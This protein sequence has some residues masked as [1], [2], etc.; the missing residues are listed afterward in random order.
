[1]R[2]HQALLSIIFGI[3]LVLVSAQR[4]RADF[5]GGDAFKEQATSS[6]VTCHSDVDCRAQGLQLVLLF[7]NGTGDGPNGQVPT[8]PEVLRELPRLTL[9]AQ[10][11]ATIWGDTILEGSYEAAGATTLDRVEGILQNGRLVSYRIT[12]SAKAWRL[13]DDG[14]KC[15]EGRIEEASYVSKSLR[16]WLRDELSMATFK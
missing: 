3:A 7:D 1:M 6:P 4:A 10:D 15:C 9:I 5:D 12:Y 16:S 8:A 11:Q 13:G 2:K 14:K